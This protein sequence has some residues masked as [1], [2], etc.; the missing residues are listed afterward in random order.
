MALLMSC[1][2]SLVITV[3]NVGFVDQ[4]M[5][6][7]LKAWGMAFVVAFPVVVLISPV[8]KKLVSIIIDNE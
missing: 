6:I 3:F 1:V 5:N 4:I 8:V 7:W 2:M